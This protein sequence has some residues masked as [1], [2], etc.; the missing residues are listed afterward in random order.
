M[1]KNI[2]IIRRYRLPKYNKNSLAS[3][4]K[5]WVKGRN[6]R[7]RY[8][9]IGPLFSHNIASFYEIEAPGVIPLWMSGT[10]T[11]V[12]ANLEIY[13]EESVLYLYVNKETF[14]QIFQDV[15]DG[16][17]RPYVEQYGG[18]LIDISPIILDKG[19]L[20]WL[21]RHFSTQSIHDIFIKALNQGDI[22]G[23]PLLMPQSQA[24]SRIE[25]IRLDPGTEEIQTASEEVSVPAGVTIKVK[26]SRTIE[27]TVSID[28][29][30]TSNV[31]VESGFK[32][33][34]SASIRGEIGQAQGRTYQESETL[35][36]E[37]ALSGETNTRYRLTW[38]DV[39]RKGMAEFQ[40]GKDNQVLPFRFREWTKLDVF[41]LGLER[42]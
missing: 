16:V 13:Y 31:S 34:I 26:R 3:D 20:P 42:R 35:E 27:H 10:Q 37:V 30:L 24:R 17:I 23:S 39:W 2:W 28:W 29:Q 36:Y 6:G 22:E 33:F 18:N 7:V 40:I 12:A 8:E 9:H 11:S 5:A 25:H 32:P 14:P 4:I 19:L 15:N 21:M 1:S 38:T 41:P